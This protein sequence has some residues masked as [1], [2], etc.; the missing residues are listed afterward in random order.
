MILPR[1]AARSTGTDRESTATDNASTATDSRASLP[2]T[3]EC[4]MKQNSGGGLSQVVFSSVC[5]L[6]N[7]AGWIGSMRMYAR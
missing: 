3:N 6:V 1:D 2:L 7:D 4:E 5:W